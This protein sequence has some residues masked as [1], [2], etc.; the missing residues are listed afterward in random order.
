MKRYIKTLGTLF[1]L[2]AV[3]LASAPAGAGTGHGGGS[4]HR[5]DS[6]GSKA[7][8]GDASALATTYVTQTFQLTLYGTAPRGDAMFVMYHYR[9]PDGTGMG[10]VVHVFCGDYRN[11]FED[12][13]AKP[14][15]RG[16]GTVYTKSISVPKGSTITFFFN[17]QKAS[18]ATGASAVFYKGSHRLYYNW[19]D[20]AWYRYGG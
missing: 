2:L 4:G 11:A 7:I 16:G 3:L 5:V 14:A 13:P 15:C 12:L 8:R 20:R 10:S 6:A 1:A 17:R 19:L 9:K 18:H